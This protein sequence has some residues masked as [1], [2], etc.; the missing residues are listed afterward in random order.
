MTHPSPSP[1]HSHAP[2]YQQHGVSSAFHVRASAA[3][4]RRID[5]SPDQPPTARPM[6]SSRFV[7]RDGESGE[8]SRKRI[9]L[10]LLAPPLKRCQS[11]FPH[12]HG[13]KESSWKKAGRDSAH[14][15]GNCFPR[16]SQFRAWLPCCGPFH[17]CVRRSCVCVEQKYRPLRGSDSARIQPELQAVNIQPP[18]CLVSSGQCIR[19]GVLAAWK[20]AGENLGCQA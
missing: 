6:G 19:C 13:T 16:L 9:Q 10:V 5:V 1:G 4:R 14:C 3:L 7:M 18:A 12:P 11:Q 8:K 15:G 17:G 2:K 20:S